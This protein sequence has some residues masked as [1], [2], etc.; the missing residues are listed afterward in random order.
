MID[1]APTT[2]QRL[3]QAAN[4][5]GLTPE[6]FLERLLFDYDQEQA[7]INQAE[8]AFNEPGAIS[9]SELKQKYRL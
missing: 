7:D 4:H 9:L 1:I 6:K 3:I 5:E 2:E 8:L